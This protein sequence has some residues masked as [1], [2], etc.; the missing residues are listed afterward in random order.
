LRL[1][2]IFASQ[3]TTNARSGNE[4]E[5]SFEVVIGRQAERNGK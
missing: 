3:D 2:R 5:E 4:E 1:E